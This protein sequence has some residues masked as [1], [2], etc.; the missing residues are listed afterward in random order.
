MDGLTHNAVRIDYV[1]Y[2]GDELE[3]LWIETVDTRSLFGTE[4]SDHHPVVARFALK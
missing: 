4:P 3:L 1:F 2:R